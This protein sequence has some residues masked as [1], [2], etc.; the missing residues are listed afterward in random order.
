MS[1][2]HELGQEGFLWNSDDSGG[3]CGG[4]GGKQ[5]PVPPPEKGKKTDR[6][7][8]K[9]AKIGVES[10]DHEVHIWTERERRKK[11]RNMFSNLHAL[12]PQLPPKADKSTIVDEAVNYIQTLQHT[13]QKLQKQK[14]EKLRSSSASTATFAYD[15]SSSPTTIITSN[16]TQFPAAAADSCT[17]ESFLADQI[18]SNAHSSQNP[19]PSFTCN[20]SPVA[21]QTW[22]SA[23]VVLNIC[24]DEAHFSVCCPKNKLGF[25]TTICYL[26]EKYNMEVVSAHVSSDFHRSIYMIQARA[27]MRC[28]NQLVD[29]FGTDEMFKQVARDIML[30]ISN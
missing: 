21:F 4:E 26:L 24:G 19:N 5:P 13:L 15:P 11:M 3:C 8:K 27:N 20:P 7:N 28:E 22:T 23:N 12:L 9:R 14:L 29:I 25:F 18:S 6:N 17:R 10:P 2:I 16:Q 30:C 1:D